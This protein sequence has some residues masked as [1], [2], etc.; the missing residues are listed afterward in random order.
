MKDVKRVLVIICLTIGTLGMFGAY[1]ESS[2]IWIYHERIEDVAIIEQLTYYN[3]DP[4]Q[5]DDTPFIT[6][7]QW[8][9]DT[10]KLNTCELRWMAV[11]QVMIRNKIVYYG[12][13]VHLQ[14]NDPEIDGYWIIADCMAKRWD[15]YGKNGYCGD[16]LFSLNRKTKKGYWKNVK[17]TK[18]RFKL[19]KSVL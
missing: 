18:H 1:N 16:L 7:P 14:A 10:T 2:A 4:K 11:S 12:D 5:T 3:P 13:T 8:E 19:T 6:A 17:L 15:N 9:I